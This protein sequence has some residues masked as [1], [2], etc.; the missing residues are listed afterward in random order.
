[1]LDPIYHNDIKITLKSLFLYKK[2]LFCH[3]VR[4]FAIDVITFPENLFVDFKETRSV[5]MKIFRIF[6]LSF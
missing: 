3:N 5:T 1:M 6:L 2:W 4:N